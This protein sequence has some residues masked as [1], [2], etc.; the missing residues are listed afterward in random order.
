[1]R[2]K[3]DIRALRKRLDGKPA[4]ALEDE[5][6][7]FEPWESDLKTSHRLLRETVVC[8]ANA[9]GGTIVMGVR[10]GVRTRPGCSLIMSDL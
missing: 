4:D 6:L 10:E 5:D 3:E 7:E 9:W 2:Q 8:L 1:M